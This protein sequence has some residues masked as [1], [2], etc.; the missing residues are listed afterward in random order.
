MIAYNDL[1]ALGFC[2]HLG[3]T[4]VRVP[5]QVSVVGFDNIPDTTLVDPPLTTI[6]AP[7]VSIGSTAVT[8]LI[9]RRRPVGADQRES[10]RLPAR[11]VI[12]GSTGPAPR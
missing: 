4:G 7:Q 8:Y 1:M 10:L 9:G 5:E 3:E 12:R 11:L 6:A 2:Q